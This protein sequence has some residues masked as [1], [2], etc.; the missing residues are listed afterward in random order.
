VMNKHNEAHPFQPSWCTT[1]AD[2]EPFLKDGAHRWA[3]LVGL[4]GYRST[5][6]HWIIVLKYR[7]R[8]AGM[9]CRPTQLDAGW[10]ECHFPSPPCAEPRRGGHAMDLAA[11]TAFGG[12]LPEYIHAGIPHPI[13][14]FDD[15]GALCKTWQPPGPGGLEARRSA[16]HARLAAEY[17]LGPVLGWMPDP[18]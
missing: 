16:H 1:W 9:V 8:D 14:H 10:S 5:T 12:L 18:V 2:F 13:D 7:V 6:P 3:E 15:A 17:G 4:S 11:T